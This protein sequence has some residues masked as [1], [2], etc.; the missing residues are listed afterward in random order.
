MS[1]YISKLAREQALRKVDA[2]KPLRIERTQADIDKALMKNSKCCAFARATKRMYKVENAYFF[3]TAAW[4][5]YSDRLVRY[6]LPPSVQKEIVSFDRSKIMAVGVYQLSP[7]DKSHTMKAVMQRS[8]KRPGRHQPARGKIKRG[9]VHQTS[10][11]RGLREPTA[12]A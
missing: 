12:V 5:Q 8:K 11:V 1:T 4:L 7:P 3:R 6:L 9:V 2:R 10:M